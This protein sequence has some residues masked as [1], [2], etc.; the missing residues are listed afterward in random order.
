MRILISENNHDIQQLYKMIFAPYYAEIN[1]AD[2]ARQTEQLAGRNH[3]DMVFVDV[4]FPA[5]E[6]L[7][8]S[9]SLRRKDPDR[10][11]VLVSSVPLRTRLLDTP[12]LKSSNAVLMKPFDIQKMRLLIE[13]FQPSSGAQES[14]QTQPSV[15]YL[16]PVF[17]A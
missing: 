6:G 16:E 1:F 15:P 10:P 14:K 4:N 7:A 2:D 3:F 9:K 17:N 11:V 12:T 13:Q 8:V 5:M